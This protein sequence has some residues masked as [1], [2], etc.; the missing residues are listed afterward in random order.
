MKP[1]PREL[2]ERARLAKPVPP[3][4]LGLQRFPDDRACEVCGA[5][6]SDE[7]RHK[8]WHDLG[9]G[10]ILSMLS[11]AIRDSGPRVA[12]EIRRIADAD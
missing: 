6:V 5:L 8:R 10:E 1:T 4:E 3:E 11:K 12:D 7:A 2:V 9:N